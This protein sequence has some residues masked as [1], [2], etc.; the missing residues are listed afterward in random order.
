[1]AYY[2]VAGQLVE[3]VYTGQTEIAED[4][5]ESKPRKFGRPNRLEPLAP[6]QDPLVKTALI[7][8]YTEKIKQKDEEIKRMREQLIARTITDEGDNKKKNN[9]KTI[10]LSKSTLQSKAIPTASAESVHKEVMLASKIN[11]VP[12]FLTHLTSLVKIPVALRAI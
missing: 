2:P 4:A 1:M 6:G 5:V 12:S 7:E 10:P 9:N 11:F 8:Q 3:S